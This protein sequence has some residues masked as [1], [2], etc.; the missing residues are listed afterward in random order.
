MN[1]TQTTAKTSWFL[2]ET[3]AS[4][5][6]STDSALTGEYYVHIIVQ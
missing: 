3:E 2:D 4:P 5:G 6:S 1:Q